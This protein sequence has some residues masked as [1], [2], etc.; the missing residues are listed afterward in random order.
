MAPNAEMNAEERACCRAM[1][2]QCE[3]MDMSGS[4]GC[5]QKTPASVHDN[6]LDTKAVVF[7]PAV[8]HVIWLAAFELVN[9]YVTVIGW[10]EHPGY[11]L[12]KS[13][14]TSISILRI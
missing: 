8:A 7:H 1:H 5:C 12:P 10:V 4:Q 14:P 6:A 11:S 3:Q 13:P 9:P 2:N